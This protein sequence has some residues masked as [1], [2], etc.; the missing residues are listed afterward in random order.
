MSGFCKHSNERSGFLRGEDVGQQIV[1]HFLQ[2]EL[3][4]GNNLVGCFM[5]W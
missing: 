2:N 4:E 1:Y 5:F 3:K